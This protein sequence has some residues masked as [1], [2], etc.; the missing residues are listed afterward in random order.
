VDVLLTT[1]SSEL[2]KTAAEEGSRRDTYFRQ[3]ATA[4]PFAVATAAA[5]FPKG[6]VDST[7]EKVIRGDVKQISLPKGEELAKA[8]VKPGLPIDQK[9]GLPYESPPWRR[10]TGRSV[11]R[12][13]AGLLTSPVFLSGLKDLKDGETPQERQ[14]GVAKVLAS[15]FVFTGIKGGAEAG[16][17]WAGILPSP[18]LRA[19]IL[20]TVGPRSMVGLGTAAFTAATAAKSLKK[21]KGKEGKEP[22]KLK[23]FTQRWLLPAGVGLA[24]GLFK[25]T[26]DELW[27]GGARARGIDPETGRPYGK[28]TV[29]GLKKYLKEIQ[30]PGA[31]GPKKS[32][33]LSGE[34]VS[35]PGA[36]R[37]V[38]AKAGGRGAAGVIGALALTEIAR[39]VLE[40]TK[41]IKL[42]QIKSKPGYELRSSGKNPKVKRWHKTKTAADPLGDLEKTRN[43]KA[44]AEAGGMYFGPTPNEIY[45]HVRNWGRDRND[46]DIYEQYK[47]IKAHNP[48]RT[49]TR[50]AV[51]Y[52]LHDELTGRGHKLPDPAM[53]SQVTGRV[54]EPTMVDTA[55]LAAVI[56]SPYLLWNFGMA[57]MEPD[58][59]DKVLADAM[60][61]MFIAGKFGTE[62]APLNMWGNPMPAYDFEEDILK[63]PPKGERHAADVAHELGHA[64]AGPEHRAFLANKKMLVASNIGKAVSI[65]LPLLALEGSGDSS[66]ATKEE[67][68]SRARFIERVGVVAGILQSPIASAEILSNRNALQMLEEA[69]KATGA[70]KDVAIKKMV[71]RAGPAFLAGSAMPMLAPFIVSRHL[72]SKARKS[73][74]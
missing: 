26:F 31:F 74:G 25:G 8:R 38:A 42:D 60:D 73:R 59:K 24:G 35:H 12:L 6:Y 19:K 20:N 36:L 56:S 27:A 39:A 64:V 44:E 32:L 16:I 29:A 52:G 2:I 37:D 65:I 41:K 61:R 43:W 70:G 30:E 18:E 63:L 3:I 51:Y 58:D 28:P 49:P 40:P 10:A 13:G 9:T 53:R 69:A 1:F 45:G 72:R 4:A 15:G 71:Q 54:R 46:A 33:A 11:G 50:R 47:I 21:P 66:F 7:V 62:D 55:L 5:D 67:L 17:E 22:T 23:Q 34:L 57:K 48:E 14:R 68:E